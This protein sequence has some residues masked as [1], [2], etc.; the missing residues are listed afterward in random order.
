MGIAGLVLLLVTCGQA[1]GQKERP[2]AAPRTFHKIRP[3]AVAGLF[4]PQDKEQL[5]RTVDQMLARAK[6]AGLKNLRGLVCPHAGY[7]FSGQTVAAA[8]KQLA[9]CDFRTVIV[10]GPSHY[11]DLAGAAVADADA[12]AT[13]LGAMPIAAWAADLAQAKP[14]ALDPACD[15]QRPAW[16]ER[17]SRAAPPPGEDRPHTWEH[18]VEVQVPFLQRVAG[19]AEL[20]PIVVGRLRPEEAA[21]VLAKHL[22]DRTLLV[23]SSDLSHYYP[24]ETANRM[25]AA[26]VK[27]I[28]DLDL[29]TMRDQEA[30]G[31]LPILVLMHVA[32]QQHWKPVLLAACNSGD[33]SGDKSGVVG[34]AAIA[35]CAPAGE[36]PPREAEKPAA[37]ATPPQRYTPQDRRFLLELAR[38]T[39]QQ[40]TAGLESAEPPP[41]DLSARL[42]EVRGCFVTL[43]QQGRLRGCIGEIFPRE[44]LYRA[45][46]HMAKSAALDDPRFNPVK[47]EELG[48]IDIEISVLTRPEP[49]EFSSPDELL[50]KLRPGVDGVVLRAGDAQ[51]TYLPQ[52]WQELPAKEAFLD[53]LAEKAG[54]PASAWRGREAR[55]LTYQVE[56]F[57]EPVHGRSGD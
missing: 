13:P 12:Y 7:E 27:A 56:A 35:F 43:K 24:Y 50:A 4:Y 18:S 10:M 17:S 30:C 49:L 20:V 8:Y 22:D 48:R 51:A 23:A 3:A 53:H 14:F 25:D 31:K 37:G 42:A 54:L 28:C 44:P 15:V 55:V 38:N 52:V 33:T 9:G 5:A 2:A 45:V 34:Y 11:A 57:R 32:R 40:A 21:T 29:D 36:T 47:P 46:L 41:A 16:W 1:H 19:R 39:I 26:C 6:P